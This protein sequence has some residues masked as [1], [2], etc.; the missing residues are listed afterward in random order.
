M[1]VNAWHMGGRVSFF[2]LLLGIAVLGKILGCGWA[3]MPED[4]PAANP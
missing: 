2:G 4:S 3:R 1:E